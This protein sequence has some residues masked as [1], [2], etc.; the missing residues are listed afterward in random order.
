VSTVVR[1]DADVEQTPT[2]FG[3][4]RWMASAELTGTDITLGRVVIEPGMQ[5]DRHAHPDCQEVPYLL[6]GRLE[7]TLGDESV[8]METGDSIV[9]PPGASHNA[10]SIGD[11][12]ADM[13]VAYSSGDRGYAAQD[14]PEQE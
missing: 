10:R 2:G 5:N 7:H 14:S 9:V 11:V 4:M 12:A 1:R 13:I 6:A 8:T 3:S